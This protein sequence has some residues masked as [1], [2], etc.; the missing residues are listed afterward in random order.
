MTSSKYTLMSSHQWQLPKINSRISIPCNQHY[1]DVEGDVSGIYSEGI[2]IVRR[3]HP[4]ACRSCATVQ[5]RAFRRTN[6]V[7]CFLAHN[8]S[9]IVGVYTRSQY[10]PQRPRTGSRASIY[11][12]SNLIPRSTEI[13]TRSTNW[14]P[15]D[16]NAHSPCTIS[17]INIVF[18]QQWHP[19]ILLWRRY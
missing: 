10:P 16:A 4:H 6:L 12:L 17:P 13:G 14:N 15:D 8:S 18:S 1:H 5:I 11:N 2:F 9:A 7:T 19:S 3:E